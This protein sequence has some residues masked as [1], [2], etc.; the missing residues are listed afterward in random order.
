MIKVYACLCGN[1]VN[2][3]DDPTAKVG[4][5][6]KDPNTWYE[7]NAELW[8]PVKKEEHSYYYLDYVK[9]FYQGTQYRINPIFIQIVDD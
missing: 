2:L 9:I 6:R 5:S 7:E 3:T 8:S 1:W 4:E